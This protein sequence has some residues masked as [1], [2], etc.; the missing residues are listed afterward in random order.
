VTEPSSPTKRFDVAV[1]VRNFEIELFWKRSV[2]FWGFISSAFVGYAALRKANPD[3]GLVV[4]CFGMVCSCA[5]SLLNRGSKYWQESWEAKVEKAEPGVTGRFF[6]LEEPAQIH[7][8][9]WLRARQYSVSR[10]AIALSDYVSLLWFALVTAELF[11][12]YAPA[13]A[14]A[15]RRYAPGSFAAFSFIYLGLLLTFGR[16]RPRS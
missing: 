5:W 14:D 9:W 12:R 8:G 1:Q 4:A 11:R 16:R 7:K 13:S 2:F 6:V 3:L 10:L 15:L